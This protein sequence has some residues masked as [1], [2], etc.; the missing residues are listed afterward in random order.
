[1]QAVI[2]L[3]ARI[4][5]EEHLCYYFIFFMNYSFKQVMS[6]KILQHDHLLH[7]TSDAFSGK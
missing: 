5:R 4:I 6:N 1:M 7:A 3:L 2:I